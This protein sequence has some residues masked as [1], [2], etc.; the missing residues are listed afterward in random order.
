MSGDFSEEPA[1]LWV[2]RRVKARVKHA[3]SA[4]GET[5]SPGQTYARHVRVNHRGDRPE[6]WK[7]CARCERIYRHLCDVAISDDAPEPDLG[8]GHSYID[9]HSEP[10]PPEIAAL[11]F[12]LPGEV[13]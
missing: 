7:R 13:G 11:A 3:C 12:A 4:C 5:I 8:C 1:A 10:P 2:E 6:I 9:I